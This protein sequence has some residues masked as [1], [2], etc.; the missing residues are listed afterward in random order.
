MPENLFSTASHG[1]GCLRIIIENNLSGIKYFQASNVSQFNLAVCT[2]SNFRSIKFVSFFGRRRN[3][4]YL[5]NI[6][7]MGI[8]GGFG[9]PG[10]TPY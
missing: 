2:N 9:L 7:E 10:H 8:M 5:S 4:S 1:T 3:L 6:N